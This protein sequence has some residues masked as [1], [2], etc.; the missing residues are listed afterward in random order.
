[1]HVTTDRW[2]RR[3]ILPA[4]TVVAAGALLASCGDD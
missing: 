3:S 2:M 1:M 4:I